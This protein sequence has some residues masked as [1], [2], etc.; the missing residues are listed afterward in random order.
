MHRVFRS[1]CN[2]HGNASFIH[3]QEPTPRPSS[4]CDRFVQSNSISAVSHTR[5]VPP[6]PGEHRI[7]SMESVLEDPGTLWRWR[8]PS[9]LDVLETEVLREHITLFAARAA[10]RGAQTHS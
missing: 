2:A 4:T 3:R 7:Y 6:R 5:H 1:S 9:V 8:A 10:V